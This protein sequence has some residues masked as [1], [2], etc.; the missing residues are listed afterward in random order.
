MWG[1]RLCRNQT[2][3]QEP[4]ESTDYHSTLAE[5]RQRIKEYPPDDS[6]DDG[7][8]RH[9]NDEREISYIDIIPTPSEITSSRPPFLPSDA[10]NAAPHFLP[11]GW[12]R[13]LD[14]QFRLSREDMLSDLRDGLNEFIRA[15][16]KPLPKG[17]ASLTP[18]SKRMTD[19]ELAIVHQHVNVYES[20]GFN[21]LKQVAHCGVGAEVS[22]R[23]PEMRTENTYAN[24]REFWMNSK[25]RLMEQQ[26]VCFLWRAGEEEK[27]PDI[28]IGQNPF[29]ITFGVIIHRDL[30]KLSVHGNLAYLTIQFRP[31][32]YTK[33]LEGASKGRFSENFM[34]ESP[35]A[36]F[37]AFKPILEAL[38]QSPPSTMPFGRYLAQENIAA[39]A[40]IEMLFSRP[41]TP[42]ISNSICPL[43]VAGSRSSWTFVS[44]VRG[45]MRLTGCG[46]LVIWMIHRRRPWLKH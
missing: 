22:F 2:S 41:A 20:A 34:I 36:Y 6:R 30:H 13:Q 7:G 14:I 45:R 31:F 5:R 46:S 32:D 25:K 8:P 10:S 28:I 15:L 33:I 11:K 27:E 12:K 21:G 18:L 1:E 9:D 35:S 4:N 43:Y 44:L 17:Q 39:R 3:I 37:E 24:R 42:Q 16:D 26:L 29:N 19:K 40:L 38:K 23:Q